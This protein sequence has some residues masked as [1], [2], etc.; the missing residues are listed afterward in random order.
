M[1]CA[2]ISPLPLTVTEK[3][4]ILVGVD[5]KGK[6]VYFNTRWLKDNKKTIFDGEDYTASLEVLKNEIVN[7][8]RLIDSVALY[9][10]E[11]STILTLTVEEVQE[12]NGFYS[13]SKNTEIFNVLATEEYEEGVSV[14]EII[15]LQC[16][17]V[18]MKMYRRGLGG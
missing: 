18:M 9:T 13:L 7:S 15:L 17:D 14:S 11:E 2:V 8:D 6:H 16:L 3:D 5:K 12:F 4:F 1:M 10:G